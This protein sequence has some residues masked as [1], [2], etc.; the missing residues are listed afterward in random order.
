MALCEA[1]HWTAARKQK[2]YW[3]ALRIR[4]HNE[5]RISEAEVKAAENAIRNLAG[6]KER[7]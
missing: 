1:P 5:L 7:E 2:I 6:L 4:D 3:H